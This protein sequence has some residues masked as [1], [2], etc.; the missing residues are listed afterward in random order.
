MLLC[1]SRE[2][3][4]GQELV[5]KS[6]VLTDAVGEHATVVTVS[7]YAPLYIDDIPSLVGNDGLRT[8]ARPGLV[9]VNGH[10]SVVPAR[11]RAAD[12]CGVKVRPCC[13]RLQD[14]AFGAR[15][16]PRL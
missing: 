11:T 4:R 7:I 9:V 8:P 6:L 10:T 2:V 15:V 5:D 12:G 14:C 3:S 13:Y 1:F 16:S